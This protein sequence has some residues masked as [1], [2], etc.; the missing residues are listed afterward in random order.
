VAQPN[1]LI[2]GAAG[3]TGTELVQQGLQRGHAVT[4]L[5]RTPQKAA[6]LPNAVKIIQGDGTDAAAV[7][8]AI[9]GHDAVLIAVGDGRTFVSGPI[10]R[11]AVAGM[12]AAGV[13]RVVLLSA[14]GIGDSAHGLH[15]FVMTRVFGKLNAD[16][17]ASEAALAG[18]G[19]DWVSV[20]PPVLG[21]GPAQGGI[22]AAEGVTINGFQTLRRADLASFMLDQIEATTFLGKKPIVYRN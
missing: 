10:T 16:K 15:G 7:A 3:K 22:K 12:K 2:I 17:L 21:T 19:L 14:Y 6:H 4:G 1:I 18:S 20:R 11:N 9:A 8:A 5:V 13:K